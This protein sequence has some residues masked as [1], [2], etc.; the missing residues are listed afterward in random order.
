MRYIYPPECITKRSR[1]QYRE[2]FVL[3][4]R[5]GIRESAWEPAE[6]N[7][8][9]R[10]HADGYAAAGVKTESARPVEQT[11][12]LFRI[13]GAD[14]PSDSVADQITVVVTPA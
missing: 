14:I 11:A 5:A 1:K 9:L 12:S 3:G 2:G 10:G 7:W 6:Q 13:G 4:W 8:Q